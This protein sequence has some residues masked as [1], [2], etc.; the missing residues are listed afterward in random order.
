MQI[1]QQVKISKYFCA[2]RINIDINH[3]KILVCA[4]KIAELPLHLRQSSMRPPF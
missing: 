3:V 1:V 2:L 4:N